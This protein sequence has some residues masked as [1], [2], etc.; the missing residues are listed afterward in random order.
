MSFSHTR[1]TCSAVEKVEAYV[2]GAEPIVVDGSRLNL[3]A[4]VAVARYNSVPELSDDEQVRSTV[5]RACSVIQDRLSSGRSLYG[6]TTGVG[7]SAFTRTNNVHELQNALTTANLNGILPTLSSVPSS[8]SMRTVLDEDFMKGTVMVRLNSLIRGHSG[9]RWTVLEAMHKLLVHDVVPLASKNNTVSASGDLG[10]LAYI[11]GTLTGRPDLRVWYGQRSERSIRPAAEVLKDIQLEP[12]TYGPKEALA[13][14]NGTAA[15]ASAAALVLY[16]ANILLLAAQG[17]TVMTIEALR[18]I[19]EPFQPFPHVVA[20]P[21]PGQI[22]IAENITR[23]AEGSKFALKEYPEGDP[24]FLLRQD[25]YHI[26][27]APQWFGPFAENLLRATESV[28]IELNSTTDNP[29]IDSDGQ[30][31]HNIYHAGNFQALTPAE[32]MDT[33]RHAILGIAKILYAQHSE[34]LN[35]MLN[36]GLPPDCAAGE[37]NLDYGLKASDLCCSAYL[38]EI[39]YLS[40]SFLPHIN[41]TEHHNQSINSMALASAR[42]ARDCVDLLRQIMAT[43][44]F[45]VCQAIDL[46]EMNNRYLSKAKELFQT[47]LPGILL[48]SEDTIMQDAVA[49]LFTTIRV[50]FGLTASMESSSRF[51][52]MLSPLITEIYTRTARNS[53][54]QLVTST[55]PVHWAEMLEVKL[56]ELF[57]QH[58]LEYFKETAGATDSLSR[59][60]RLI[61]IFIRKDLEIPMKKGMNQMDKHEI[62]TYISIIFEALGDGRMDRVFTEAVESADKL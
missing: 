28:T 41:S 32:A 55:T 45:T 3:A 44:L 24:E 53:Q 37:P 57:L 54:I 51:K 52:A 16:D 30:V 10:T 47:E 26:R 8:A 17:L 43:Y 2:H 11:A 5:H 40:G 36:R 1:V 23:M 25:R 22:E 50:Q 60:G 49:S 38:S 6:V 33:V 48:C 12:L 7:A 56:R 62:G 19:L 39:G 29:I 59:A 34:L 31:P 46:R 35:P 27:C 20:R 15:S 13:I 61:Y 4:V 21:H 58:R 14:L 42:H 9:V 18:S